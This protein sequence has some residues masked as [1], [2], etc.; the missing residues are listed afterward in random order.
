M[1][2]KQFLLICFICLLSLFASG[3]STF[4]QSTGESDEWAFEETFD[5]DPSAPSQ[6]LLPRTFD[7]VVT[8]RSHPKEHFS[9]FEPF[10]A[11]H[12][13]SCAG[14]DPGVNPL[15]QHS[16]VTNHESSG[17]N[18]DPSFYM[19]KNHM[20]SSMGD[21]AG[22]S[23]TAFWPRQAFNFNECAILEF[24]VNINREHPRSWWEVMITPRSQLKVGSASSFAPIEERYP[25]DRFV[26]SF[27]GGQR[28]I[29]VGTGALDPDGVLVKESERSIWAERFPNDP[30]NSDRR[31]RRKMHIAFVDNQI[32]WSIAKE[33]GTFDTEIVDLPQGF[34]FSE[35]LVLFKTHAYTPEK[36]GNFD[37]YTFHWDN[38]RFGGPVAGQ[39]DAYEAESVIYLQ[40]N[41]SLPIGESATT[42]ITLSSA[43]MNSILQNSETAPTLFGQVHSPLSG[44][45]MLSVNGEAPI[46]VH[47]Y[48]YSENDC[49]SDDWN[50]FQ[51]P[52]D[53]ADLLVGA[54]TFTWTIAPRP[55]CVPDRVWDG[56][57]IKSLEL[58]VEA[59]GA[60]DRVSTTPPGA[61]L[62]YNVET[63]RC[64]LQYYT[65]V[66]MMDA[67]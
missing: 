14:P 61:Q 63:N 4:A 44:Q 10:L 64:E 36:D 66:P 30:A 18:P 42:T 3:N 22:Y 8:H 17:T 40:T 1:N 54:N 27:L 45:V 6:S 50:S 37:T 56:F 60:F 15:P 32:H 57:S 25:E 35:G 23:V 43:A 49:Y 46:A 26:F 51:L 12:A 33:D 29:E 20:M 58:Q 55:D 11:D 19:C 7:Y 41:G 48:E 31:V 38:I 52:M 5:G 16:V 2:T 53:P 9:V 28:E 59:A 67:R 13:E 47:P 39:Y 62:I 34:P 24:D 65:Y 21:V